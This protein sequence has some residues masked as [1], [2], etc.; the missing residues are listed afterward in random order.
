MLLALYMRGRSFCACR[1]GRRRSRGYGSSSSILRRDQRGCASEGHH[2][3]GTARFFCK[4][5]IG[6]TALAT[7]IHQRR[8]TSSCGGQAF[9]AERTVGPDRGE[10][11]TEARN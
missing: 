5:S 9:I 11:D 6:E 7:S 4:L 2:P 10:L 3:Y 1:K 8:L